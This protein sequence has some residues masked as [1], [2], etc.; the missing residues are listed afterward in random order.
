MAEKYKC[1][2]EFFTTRL[3][4]FNEYEI[5]GTTY[6][7]I[8]TYIHTHIH[9]YIH[10]YIQ[11]LLTFNTLMWG[12]LRLAPTIAKKSDVSPQVLEAVSK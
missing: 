5:Y 12:S 6:E 3:S 10:T 4:L 8:Y 7:Y 11:T 1:I 9:T 2:F